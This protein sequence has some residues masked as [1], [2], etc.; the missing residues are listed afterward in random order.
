M[1]RTL[2]AALTTLVLLAVVVAGAAA[3]G[4]DRAAAGRGAAWLAG[5]TG[6]DGQGAD[7]DAAVAL[8]AAGRLT[9][10]VAG[11]RAA[12]L[13]RAAGSY[14]RTPGSTAKTILGLT[15]LGMSRPQCAGRTNL[16]A[17]MLAFGHRGRFS[18]N[19]FDQSLPMLALRALGTRPSDNQLRVLAGMR[20]GGGWAYL[21][22]QGDD[23]SSTALAILALRAGHVSAHSP[24][25]R[26]GLSWLAH[27]R[28]RGGGYAMGR[29]DRS[30][31]NS[32][33]LVLEAKRAVG[34]SDPRARRALRAMQRRDGSFG[35][36]RSGA[37]STVIATND[38]VVALTGSHLPVAAR[39]SLPSG[40]CS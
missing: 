32:T 25:I 30:E 15:A 20:G 2:R 18:A 3:A 35:F 21:P 8:R 37:G 7:A 19:V 5:H 1:S 6:S 27:H 39:R 16:L 36:T 28:A 12:T 22:G 31:A 4:G 24:S 17:R 34:S 9:H 40:R 11:R 10:A 23:P 14:D 26:A 38:A 13:R 33:A 29:R